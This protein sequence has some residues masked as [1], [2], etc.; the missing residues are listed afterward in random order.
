VRHLVFA[1]ME[2]VDDGLHTAE[3]AG[4]P[5]AVAVLTAAGVPASRGCPGG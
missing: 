3:E 2:A 4:T 1:V 5:A